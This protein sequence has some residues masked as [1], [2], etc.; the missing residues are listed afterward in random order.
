MPA[1]S[2][3]ADYGIDAPNVLRNFF[4]LGAP[5]LLLDIV[6]LRQV[7]LGSIDFLPRPMFFYTSIFLILRPSPAMPAKK[8][9]A[10]P[11]AG[12]KFCRYRRSRAG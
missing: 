9:F 7:H 8:S 12:F 10:H 2:D 11:L 3:K 1:P 4:L 5:C 6:G